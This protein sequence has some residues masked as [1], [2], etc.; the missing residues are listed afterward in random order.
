[1][2]RVA[3]LSMEEGRTFHDPERAEGGVADEQKAA[4]GWRRRKRL[5]IGKNIP[6]DSTP[7][8]RR[9]LSRRQEEG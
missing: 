7:Y 3:G 6:T 5:E 4:G 2:T 9:Y 8:D 1:M